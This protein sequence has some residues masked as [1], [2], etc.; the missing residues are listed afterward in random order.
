MNRK[1]FSVDGFT[2]EFRGKV[3]SVLNGFI[4]YLSVRCAELTATDVGRKIIHRFRRDS[5]R[6]VDSSQ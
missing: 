1:Q 6:P 3:E 5:I 4:F 2:D